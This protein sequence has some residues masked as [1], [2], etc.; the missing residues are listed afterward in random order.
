MMAHQASWS[1]NH[2]G[3]QTITTEQQQMDKTWKI[4]GSPPRQNTI[5]ETTQQ[6]QLLLQQEQVE[7]KDRRRSIS[8]S[9]TSSDWP[10]FGGAFQWEG[11]SIFNDSSTELTSSS[12]HYS[13]H[14]HHL[15]PPSPLFSSHPYYQPRSRSLS[16][17]MGQ[18]PTN[19]GY[20]YYSNSRGL[21]TTMEEEDDNDKMSTTATRKTVNHSQQQQSNI[22]NKTN[23]LDIQLNRIR[24]RS[25][26]SG[27]SF[28]SMGRIN[29][30]PTSPL[31]PSSSSSSFW[32][33]LVLQP[34]P[35]S[36]QPLTPLPRTINTTNT[37]STTRHPPLRRGSE[38]HQQQPYEDYFQRYPPLFETNTA[39]SN[40]TSTAGGTRFSNLFQQQQQ[41]HQRRA[42]QPFTFSDPVTISSDMR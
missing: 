9:S 37:I 7:T 38:Q 10:S 29:P 11:P 19:F 42:S 28:N 31:T 2:D 39:T 20:E 27:G 5:E 3:D 6:Q 8:S 26:S 1:S 16:F 13:Q 41:Q 21:D 4:V 24:I 18:D 23:D 35:P 40:D 30:S 12:N 32:P 36:S 34:A 17:S 22:N 25:Q 33:P 14:P 15:P